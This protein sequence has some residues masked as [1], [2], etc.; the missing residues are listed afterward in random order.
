MNTITRRLTALALCVML[1]LTPSLAAAQDAPWSAQVLITLG[2][3]TQ[4]LVPAQL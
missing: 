4:A 3:G 1:A 2:D